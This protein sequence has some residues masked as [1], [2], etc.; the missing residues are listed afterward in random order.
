MTAAVVSSSDRLV[1]AL[2]LALLIHAMIVLG[3][4][5]SPD[6]R[7]N[8]SKTL[9]VTLASYRSD[10]APEKADFLAQ[11]NQ[12]GSGTEEDARMLTTLLLPQCR[13]RKYPPPKLLPTRHLQ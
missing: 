8:L 13:S 9:E 4:S 12:E 10:K 3:V 5:F 1:F 2:F 6:D 11:E 7:S